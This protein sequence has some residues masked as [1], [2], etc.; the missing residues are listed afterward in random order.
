MADRFGLV[1]EPRHVVVSDPDVARV[2]WESLE[3]LGERDA[4]VLDLHLRHGYE[5]SRWRRSS[6]R[7]RRRPRE[8]VTRLRTRLGSLLR[9]RLLWS[10]GEPRCEALA[11]ALGTAGAD[12]FDRTTAGVIARHASRCEDCT[13][14]AMMGVPPADLVA[15][16]P[17]VDR[18][19]RGR[20]GD[21]LRTRQPRMHIDG[22]RH[23]P[24]ALAQP[25]Q[26]RC[27]GGGQGGF[28]AGQRWCRP[29][30]SWPSASLRASCCSPKQHGPGRRLRPRP[31]PPVDDG[32]PNNPFGVAPIDR[33]TLNPTTIAAPAPPPVLGWEVNTDLVTTARLEG[34]NFEDERLPGSAPVCPGAVANRRV[35]ASRGPTSTP[36][37]PDEEGDELETAEVVLTVQ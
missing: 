12:R 23:S 26:A 5:Y 17:V 20:R 19:E 6:A 3:T 4:S 15:A 25:S 11:G 18:A 27:G 29:R 14:V 30:L 33:F 24:W 8:V 7:A 21:R 13:P 32:D 34:P 37:S 35:P 10:G 9:A 22:S 16:L 28:S 31:A 2:L 1:D 36:S